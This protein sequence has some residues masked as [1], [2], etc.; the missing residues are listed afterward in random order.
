ME[1]C[2]SID[3]SYGAAIAELKMRMNTLPK[4]ATGDYEGSVFEAYSSRVEEAEEVRY[5]F[6]F[7]SSSEMARVHV[8]ADVAFFFYLFRVFVLLHFPSVLC[9]QSLHLRPLH[10]LPHIGYSLP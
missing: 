1:G 3:Y 8:Q 5:S 4:S 10:Y 9:G 2:S 6:I 7:F